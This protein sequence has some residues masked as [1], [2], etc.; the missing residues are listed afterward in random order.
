MSGKDP[1][2][3]CRRHKRRGFD[4]WVG[5]IPWRRERLPAPVFCPGECHGLYSP[6]GRK[7]LDTTEHFSHVLGT[8]LRSGWSR[9][10]PVTPQRHLC[11]LALLP[12][13]QGSQRPRCLRS[14]EVRSLRWVSLGVD[15]GVGRATLSEGSRGL[16]PASPSFLEA[17]VSLPLRLHCRPRLHATGL[18]SVRFP[19]PLLSRTLVMAFGALLGNPSIS[20]LKGH[21][22]IPPAMSH[23][24][25][26]IHTSGD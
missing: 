22:L 2:C 5:K 8:E 21:T 18:L 17:Q 16:L 11:P 13:L 3:Q 23:I 26:C 12:A 9:G 24:R 14:T 6:R 25:Q 20:H 4:P 19:C 10:L 7:E 1:A 15:Q